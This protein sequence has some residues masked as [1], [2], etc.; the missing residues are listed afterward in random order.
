MTERIILVPEGTHFRTFVG[1]RGSLELLP[2]GTVEREC[3]ARGER[4][5]ALS[6][7]GEMLD[8]LWESRTPGE[9]PQAPERAFLADLRALGESARG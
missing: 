2:L 6:E 4:V 3:A 1:S 8:S 5:Y 9:P 7:V